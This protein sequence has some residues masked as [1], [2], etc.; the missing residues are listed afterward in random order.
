MQVI[1]GD[2]QLCLFHCIVGRHSWD[3]PGKEFGK[4]IVEGITNIPRQL[5]CLGEINPTEN[6]QNAVKVSD[7]PALFLLHS[8]KT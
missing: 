5:K 6:S 2:Q 1:V 4:R 8:G 7:Q 3:A